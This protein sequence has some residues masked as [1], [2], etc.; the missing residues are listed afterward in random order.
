MPTGDTPTAGADERANAQAVFDLI[1]QLKLGHDTAAQLLVSVVYSLGRDYP[2]C[3]LRIAQLAQQCA[4]KLMGLHIDQEATQ[5]ATS[6][7]RSAGGSFH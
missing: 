6:P 4:T 5:V 3:R 1:H 7:L 2:C